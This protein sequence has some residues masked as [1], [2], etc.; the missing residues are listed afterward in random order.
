MDGKKLGRFTIRFF[1]GMIQ[2]GSIK[3]EFSHIRG[4]FISF[5]NEW[6]LLVD[7]DHLG[8]IL[9]N[10]CMYIYICIII[11]V[12][13]YTYVYI[14]IYVYIIYNIY[15]YWGSSLHPQWEIRNLTQPV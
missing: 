14:Y 8:F 13:I 3:L 9:P 6:L 10:I 1:R 5:H 7:D 11:Y 15:I 4:V 12:Y 2:T